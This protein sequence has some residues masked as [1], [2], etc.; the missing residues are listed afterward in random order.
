M[1]VVAIVVAGAEPAHPL[2]V[3]LTERGLQKPLRRV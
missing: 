3:F 2:V 1:I